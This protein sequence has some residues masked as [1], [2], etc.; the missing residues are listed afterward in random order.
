MFPILAIQLPIAIQVALTVASVAVFALGAVY[1]ERKVSAFI[2]DR[3]GPMEAGPYGAM[4]T[5]ADVLK[6]VL[7]EPIIP[8]A[9]D[10][11]LFI[12]AP[13]VIFVAVF[14]GIGALAIIP[15]A[16]G[17][18]LNVGLL[19]LLGVVAIDIIGL[20]MAGWGSANKY[21]L[22]GS[23]RS[24]NQIVAYE[25]P[26]ALALLSGVMMLGTLSI[27]AISAR[28]GIYSDQD[29]FFLG[30]WN[31]TEMG[32]ILGWSVIRY[33]HLLIAFVVYFIASLAESNRAPFDLPEAESELVS[34][35]HV[36][37]SGFRFALVMLSEYGKML[38]TSILAVTV[39]LGGWN[40]ILPNIHMGDTSLLLAS[41]TSGE[42]GT[43]AGALWGAFWILSKS[44]L[45]VLLQIYIRWTYPRVRIDQ[46]MTISWKYLTPVAFGLFIL[47]GLWKLAEVYGQM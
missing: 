37:Y 8:K 39:F 12:L 44:M 47:S 38:I 3:L 21:A 32:G 36:E 4:Q 40:T 19:F 43:V 30:I 11:P 1:A 7:K 45:L 46:L 31:V 28:Q 27:Q 5:L 22:I 14:A 20:L 29:T 15:K 6:L 24:V 41:W 25:V 23:A 17:T 16:P 35:F 18:D 42:P 10:K 9:A 2:Q 13:P 33:P 26:A 34:G